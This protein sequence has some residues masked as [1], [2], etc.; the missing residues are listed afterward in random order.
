V[1]LQSGWQRTE[2]VRGQYDFAWLDTVVDNLAK[3]GM[4]P[5]ICLC[6]GNELYTP[7][8]KKYYGAVGIPPIKTAE[9]RQAWAAY[10]TA[11]AKHFKGRV[12]LYEIWNEPTGLN[13]WKSGVNPVE[14]GEFAIA[15]AKAVRA[16]DPGAQIA[17][18]VIT[19]RLDKMPFVAAALDTGLASHLDIFTYHY[20][21]TTELGYRHK[22]EA[23]K[24]LLHAYNPNIK[25]V[26]GESGTQS[27][28]DGKGALRHLAWSPNRQAKL[29]LRH[30]VTDLSLGVEFTS[31]FSTLDMIEALDGKVGVKSSYL[32]Y[33]YFGVLGADF[34]ADGRSTGEYTPKPSYYAL[35]NLCAAFAADV[36]MEPL[37]LQIIPGEGASGPEIDMANS[38]LQCLGLK[39]AN[40]A[41]ALVYW[42]ATDLLTTDYAGTLSAV[43]T[44]L[45]KPVR[46]VDLMSGAVY[47]IPEEM[48]TK[49]KMSD[50]W[51]LKNILVTDYPLMLTFGD[52]IPFKPVR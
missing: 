14:Y 23:M 13:C 29:L 48:L 25:M 35:Q 45:P 9:E 34:D 41:R 15:T 51:T 18:G 1:R 28:P 27:R 4:T 38:A 5:W 8:A 31:Y 2:M 36:S 42:N 3:R 40:G 21:T 19:G 11:T 12:A 17:G 46:L 7:E 47:E 6:Y 52:F 43:F 16:A 44:Q 20:Y 22:Y 24:A 49:F 50:T 26:Q 10:V 33:G 32:D 39:K 37:P 30:L